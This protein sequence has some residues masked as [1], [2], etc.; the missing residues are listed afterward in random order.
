MT[1]YDAALDKFA[2]V[3]FSIALIGMAISMDTFAVD[4]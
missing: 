1:Q 4:I 2:V 3:I